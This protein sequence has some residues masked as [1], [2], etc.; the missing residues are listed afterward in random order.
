MC[1]LLLGAGEGQPTAGTVTF[2]FHF[3]EWPPKT[4]A[5]VDRKI[6]YDALV[7]LEGSKNDMKFSD[8][9]GIDW[10]VRIRDCRS[11]GRFYE[12]VGDQSQNIS[13]AKKMFPGLTFRFGENCLLVRGPVYRLCE[14]EAWFA[15]K[16][17]ISR[18][19]ASKPP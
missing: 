11:S 18:G 19:S 10:I 7:A 12:N 4:P 9:G 15:S 3:A 8:S 2:S 1:A 5:D 6:Q 13:S 14:F 17:G 16:T